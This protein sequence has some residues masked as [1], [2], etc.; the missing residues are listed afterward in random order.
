MLRITTDKTCRAVTLR[1]EGRLAGPWVTLLADCWRKE[2]ADAD[3][4]ELLVD[5]NGVTFI[6]SAGRACLARI[7][8]EGAAFVADDLEIRAIVAEIAGQ[9]NKTEKR[10]EKGESR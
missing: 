8:E 4:R 2:R 7:H 6:D 5:L 10:I 3:A 9:V 1:L